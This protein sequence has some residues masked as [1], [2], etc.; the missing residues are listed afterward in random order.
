[1]FGTGTAGNI[2]PVN[3]IE[4]LD[5]LIFIPTLE[6]IQPVYKRI[7]QHLEAIQYGQIQHP[8]AV[9]IEDED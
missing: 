2:S 8:W 1:M 9:S 7:K 4:Y 5:E 3:C 6:H